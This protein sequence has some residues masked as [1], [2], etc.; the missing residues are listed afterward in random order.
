[1]LLHHPLATQL[2]SCDSPAAILSV[3][4][5][6]VQQFEQSRTSDERLGTWL[7]PTVTV[8]FAFSATLGEGVGLVILKIIISRVS[9]L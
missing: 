1:M 9:A 6:L 2:Q 4:T 7:D 8:L 3:L 5:D